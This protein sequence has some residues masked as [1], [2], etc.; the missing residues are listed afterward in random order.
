VKPP[1]GPDV[2]P[3]VGPDVVPPVGPDVVPPV[4]PDT[5]NDLS[6]IFRILQKIKLPVL[7]EVVLN[8]FKGKPELI[9][10]FIDILEGN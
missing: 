8:F 6:E 7:K 2:V 5:I 10:S 4:G 9:R 1:V 3:P